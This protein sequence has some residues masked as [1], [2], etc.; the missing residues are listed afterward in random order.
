M[1]IADNRAALGVGDQEK[2]APRALPAVTERKNGGVRV[3]SRNYCGSSPRQKSQRM[4]IYR[5]WLLLENQMQTSDDSV[6]IL[7]SADVTG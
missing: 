1:A 6:L 4:Y 7:P 5:P 2:A 3:P